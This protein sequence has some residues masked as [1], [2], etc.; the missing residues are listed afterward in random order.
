LQYFYCMQWLFYQGDC[1]IRVSRS[2][3]TSFLK[4]RTCKKLSEVA[5]T[6]TDELSSV[7]FT[8]FK[9]SMHPTGLI[10]AFQLNIPEIFSETLASP[11]CIIATPMTN[12]IS[13]HSTGSVFV[14]FC[15]K[16]F[17]IRKE[18]FMLKTWESDIFFS[19]FSEYSKAIASCNIEYT[20]N[21]HCHRKWCA[22]LYFVKYSMCC[23]EQIS[24]PFYI[25]TRVWSFR[26]HSYANFFALLLT[27]QHQFAKKFLTT[28]AILWWMRSFHHVCCS[29][30][31]ET[32]LSMP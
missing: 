6:I 2:Y 30:G 4:P 14:C 12:I 11:A 21:F 22:C 23:C 7:S 8:N 25:V 16:L 24:W 3:W 26:R 28:I 17:V 1:S 10:L 5:R 18:R 29:I 32:Q 13:V 19:T 31:E 15:F 27:S 9:C 20:V